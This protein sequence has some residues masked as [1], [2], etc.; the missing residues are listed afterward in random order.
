VIVAIDDD[1]HVV[2]LL[3]QN[4]DEAGYTVVGAKLGSEGIQT[5]RDVQPVAVTLDIMLPDTDGW[6]VLH[7]LKRDPLTDHIPVILLT[8]VDQK[9]LGYQLGAAD[10]LVKPFSAGDVLGA[11]Q[12]VAQIG[13]GGKPGRLLVVD[14]DPNIPD[15]IR[16]LLAESALQIETA[17]NGL[18]ALHAIRRRPPDVILL[19]L[20]MPELDGFG[21][22]AELQARP[23]LRTIP[24]IVLTAKLLGNDERERLQQG[25]VQVIEKQGLE[26]SGLMAALLQRLP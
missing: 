7:E 11:L 8:V 21:L 24:V 23:D 4:L 13:A 26:T 19:D 15:M 25:V 22:L 3:R 18:E 12:R 20:M 14:D 17:G 9:P 5:V 16:Q 6:Q 10:Y 2:E 1:P